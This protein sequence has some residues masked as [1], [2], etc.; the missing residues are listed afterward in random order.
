MKNLLF[1]NPMFLVGLCVLGLPIFLHLIDRKLPQKIVFP[2]IRFIHK[3][4][5]LQ[6]GKKYIRDWL[7]L[8]SRLLLL[9]LIILLFASPEFVFEN[10]IQH[11]ERADIL[12]FYDVSASMNRGKFNDFVI[13]ET[14]KVVNEHPKSR[15]ALL[16]SSNKTELKIP[17]GLSKNEILEH[18]KRMSPGYLRG[19]HYQ[20]LNDA[21]QL[22][23]EN[24]RTPKKLYIFS[25]LQKQD[26]IASKIPK[27]PIDVDIHFVKPPN[28]DE[29]NLSITGVTPEVFFKDETRILRAT[30]QIY[31]YSLVS[32][33]AEIRLNLGRQIVISL[34]RAWRRYQ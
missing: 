20:G 3:A 19:D 16:A 22:L 1:Q 34:H 13:Q 23:G 32:G 33:S 6:A 14:T 10:P 29:S 21:G 9:L 27:L 18:L 26:W 28:A 15:F 5:R 25:D 17:F 4:Q 8:L 2:S 7:V 12:L 31:N 24:N 11:S 30:I